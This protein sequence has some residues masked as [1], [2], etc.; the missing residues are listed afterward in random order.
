[1]NIY[2]D[3]YN[4]ADCFVLEN[5]QIKAVIIPQ[6]GAKVASILYKSK[7]F[8]LAA[9]PNRGYTGVNINTPF[10][11][12]DASGIDDAFPNVVES[13][14]EYSGET[15]NYTDHGEI[16]RSAFTSH[17]SGDKLICQYESCEKKY[18]YIKTIYI[19]KNSLIFDYEISNIADKPLPYM[20]TMHG[21]V[22]YEEDM[23]L[24]YPKGNYEILNVM[25]TDELGDNLK[26]H[27]FKNSYYDFTRLPPKTAN[28]HAKYYLNGEIFEGV[29]GYE[30]PTQKVKCL[31][32]F[33]KDKLPYLG[34]W[35]TVGKFR[36]DFNCAF[37]P[38]NGFYDD[39]SIAYKN[40][41]YA[42]L[43]KEA[44]CFSLEY[45][46]SSLEDN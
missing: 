36:G 10:H 45:E 13:S 9:Q 39:M 6:L 43:Q 19:K 34:F 27:S 22:R 44:F 2:K 32:K 26:V 5:E 3:I 38:S 16:W 25:Q 41:K 40:E 11:T 42:L 31:L 20:Y 1:M 35:A 30:Y 14:I 29:C 24:I 15:I 7:N 4:K 46:F 33:D 21:L 18:K 12:A 28:T 37:E 23:R 17:I 8:E